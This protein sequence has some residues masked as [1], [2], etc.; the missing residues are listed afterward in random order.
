[1]ENLGV[2]NDGCFVSKKTI[3]RRNKELQQN[4]TIRLL[5]LSSQI[6][7]RQT[8]HYGEGCFQ[9][10]TVKFDAFPTITTNFRYG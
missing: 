10:T 2:K 7:V 6:N 8:S 1:M 4:T 3:R 9:E 5:V